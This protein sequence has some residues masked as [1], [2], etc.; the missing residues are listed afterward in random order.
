M[1]EN[2]SNSKRLLG[3]LVSPIVLIRLT[4]VLVFL[5]MVGHMSAYP[6]TSTHVQQ[7]TQ[8]V[9]SMKSI[10]FVFFGE[11][12]DYWS[13]Y[14]GFGLLIGVLL[15]TLAIILWFLA[16]LAHLVPHRLGVITGIIS[17]SSLVCAYLSFRFFFTPPVLL[18]S[19][20]C[21]ILPTA[22]V[23]LLRQPLEDN[24]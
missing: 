3:F 19:V 18:Y 20:I 15:F 8:L 12:S 23:Q 17:A 6:W 10:G 24:Q 9:D 22:A 21:V 1:F 14:F 16:D 11:R 2:K 4:S 5:L 7:E 13:L